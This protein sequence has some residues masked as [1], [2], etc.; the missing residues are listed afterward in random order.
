MLSGL[1]YRGP[2]E[3]FNKDSYGTL[4]EGCAD[5]VEVTASRTS[6]GQSPL[7]ASLNPLLARNVF[8]K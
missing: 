8:L 2:L 1:L 7:S 3:V 5:G 6:A 4:V